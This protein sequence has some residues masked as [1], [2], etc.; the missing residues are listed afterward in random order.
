MAEEEKKANESDIVADKEQQEGQEEEEEE[1]LILVAQ[2]YL[3]IYHQIHIFNAER[4]AEFDESLVQMPDKV[5]ITMVDM[6]G[7]RVLLEHVQELEKARG[8]KSELLQRLIGKKDENSEF[9]LLAKSEEEAKAKAQSAQQPAEAPAVAPVAVSGPI[10]LDPDFAKNLASS[11]ATAFRSNNLTP[12]EGNLGE[13]SDVL[14]K[15]FNSYATNMQQLTEKMLDQNM[16]HFSQTQKQIQSSLDQQV[17][18]QNKMQTDWNDH[19]LANIQK[20]EDWQQQLQTKVTEQIELQNQIQSRLAEQV[21]QQSQIQSR[22]AE[23][24]NQQNLI[25]SRFA[26]NMELQNQWQ[27]QVQSQM[28]SLSMSAA[29]AASAMPQ[30]AAQLNTQTNNANSTTINN[31]NVDSSCFNGLTQTIKEAEAKRNEDFKQI[32]EVLNKN[33]AQRNEPQSLPITAITDS[34]TEALRENSKQQL[35]AIKTFGD[36]LAASLRE[37]QKELAKTLSQNAAK[38]KIYVMPE[39]IQAPTPQPKAPQ[40]T[41]Q[42]SGK[43]NFIK[44]LGDKIS[45]TTS[46]LAQNLNTPK[47]DKSK[48][49]VPEEKP[50]EKTETKNQSQQKQEHKPEQKAKTESK[51][52]PVKQNNAKPEQKSESKPEIK[53]K[54]KAEQKT[55]LKSEPQSETKIESKSAE[56]DLADLL[57]NE[58]EPTFETTANLPLPSTDDIVEKDN[59]ENLLN[60]ILED[61]ELDSEPNFADAF[62]AD[63]ATDQSIADEP[64]ANTEYVSEPPILPQQQNE[65]DLASAFLDDTPPSVT[66]TKNT[67]A[68]QE[69]SDNHDIRSDTNALLSEFLQMTEDLTNKSHTPQTSEPKSAPKQE[70][71]PAPKPEP[72]KPEPKP[73]LK[74]APEPKPKPKKTEPKPEPEPKYQPS[75]VMASRYDDAL[76]KIKDA[77]QSDESVTL[78]ELDDV[79][80][81]SLNN[82]IS[83]PQEE[84]EQSF[85]DVPLEDSDFAA[86]FDEANASTDDGQWEYV[87]ENGN[88]LPDDATGDDWEYVDENGNPLPDDAADEDWEYVDENGN[89]LPNDTT[90]DDWEYVDENGNPLPDDAADDDWEYVDEN[91]NPLP[92]DAADDDWEYVD[93]NGNPLPDDSVAE[94]PSMPPKTP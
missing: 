11:L 61:K 32:I 78:N 59:T 5:R 73:E 54:P 68:N 18:L 74:P 70:P 80:T 7:G 40:E 21:D 33:F 49:D 10:S 47:K 31:I 9:A 1:S 2:R 55:E 51:T 27:T 8:I 83:E 30:A 46:K 57:K 48:V 26:E 91:G 52:E 93:E 66:Q 69:A 62:L 12:R 3:N 17:G 20:Q 76:Q 14:S 45:E 50:A 16:A 22:F 79:N 38:E 77:L 37:T 39:Q 29:N 81:I 87:D 82:D 86:L 60:N 34:I 24:V 92:D 36:I 53:A 13:L 4:R 35:A 84:I 64:T 6:P 67:P 23:Q 71:K 25:Q 44:N 65:T 15:S 63:E 42:S 19:L 28:Q 75:K 94:D 88:P 58:P 43:S 41:S 85:D 89:P 90:D 56:I 72:K